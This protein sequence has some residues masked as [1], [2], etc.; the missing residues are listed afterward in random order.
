MSD[1]LRD[2]GRFIDRHSMVWMRWL[3]APVNRVWEAVSTQEGISKWWIVDKVEFDL[4]PGG[5]FNHH[6]EDKINDFKENEYIDFSNVS[7]GAGG[8]R[9]ELKADENGTV[10]SFIDNFKE[11]AIP[12][13][14]G[15]PIGVVQPGG[16][17]TPWSGPAGGWHA[18]IDGLET[19]LTGRTFS[20][21]YEDLQRFYAEYLADH[22]RWLEL[23]P[24]KREAAKQQTE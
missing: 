20:H 13:A 14:A 4:R 9:F 24:A 1:M 11:D 17:G 19:Y 21:S 5:M 10:F 22:F 8:M 3:D 18:I 23:M 7:F 15:D 6:W 16:P 12:P 2:A